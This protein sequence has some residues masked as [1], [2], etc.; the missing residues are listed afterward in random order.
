MCRRR[1]EMVF[2]L[3]TF[4]VSTTATGGLCRHAAAFSLSY[5]ITTPS[6]G[7]SRCKMK[8]EWELFKHYTDTIVNDWISGRQK[9]GP[10]RMRTE[11]LKKKLGLPVY[12]TIK[13]K[14]YKFK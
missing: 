13:T 6:R 10:S 11:K 9:P 5:A 7:V 2:V 4:S 14:I 1:L 3:L 8:K 12:K